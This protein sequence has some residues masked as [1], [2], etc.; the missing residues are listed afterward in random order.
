[1]KQM[2]ANVCK[3]YCRSS[4]TGLFHAPFD[5]TIKKKEVTHAQEVIFRGHRG[6]FL[7]D[8]RVFFLS[9]LNLVFQARFTADYD[10]EIVMIFSLFI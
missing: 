10:Q 7:S 8:F 6:F 3:Q 9:L 4:R 2:S 1:M 5:L